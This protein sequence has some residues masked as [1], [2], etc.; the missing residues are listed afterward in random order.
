M[1]PPWIAVPFRVVVAVHALLV[2]AQA[3]LAGNFL[4]GNA[5]ALRLHEVNGTEILM[6]VTLVQ[7]VLAIL[8]W[9]PGRGPAWPALATLLLFVA[10]ILQISYGFGN[11]LAL[12]VPLGV[13]IFGLSLTLLL[14]TGT[15]SRRPPGRRSRRW[16]SP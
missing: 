11:R 1:S 9:R 10:Q 7:L 12:H 6:P 5:E 8:V 15:L 14:G 4:V 2:F 3:A 13:A 16:R